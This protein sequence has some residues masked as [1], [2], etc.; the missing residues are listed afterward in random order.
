M[1]AVFQK[2]MIELRANRIRKGE[3]VGEQ[4]RAGAAYG[5]FAGVANMIQGARG[6]FDDDDGAPLDLR[7]KYMG[8]SGA[9]LKSDP[10]LPPDRLIDTGITR[11]TA[12][13]APVRKAT[14]LDLPRYGTAMD[15]HIAAERI[16][17]AENGLFPD[18]RTELDNPNVKAPAPAKPEVFDSAS[19]AAKLAALIANAIGS[20]VALSNT[21]Q[22]TVAKAEKPRQPTE[23]EVQKAIVDNALF[24]KS[25]GAKARQRVT[26]FKS[27]DGREIPVVLRSQRAA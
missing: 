13:A 12:D 3:R 9:V 14:H 17:R 6:G 7:A 23:A 4:P 27:E 21:S 19:F 18:A 26:I 10:A 20:A 1:S 11:P 2:R 22:T 24:L 25:D 5:E 15:G 16:Y 8:T